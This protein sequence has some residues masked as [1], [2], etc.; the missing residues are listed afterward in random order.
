MAYV[1]VD[2]R[3]Y[4]ISGSR[5]PK[6]RLNYWGCLLNQSMSLATR[7]YKLPLIYRVRLFGCSISKNPINR[8]PFLSTEPVRFKQNILFSQSNPIK[9]T[10]MS[11]WK[12][13]RQLRTV[14]CWLTAVTNK[15]AY[16][17]NTDDRLIPCAVKGFLQ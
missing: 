16:L 15:K 4:A 13:T 11:R 10:N 1:L 14:V 12:A 9:S 3:S 6:T 17:R 7:Q 2:I 5:H 8:W